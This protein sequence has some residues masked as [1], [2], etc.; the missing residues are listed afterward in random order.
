MA[1]TGSGT[2]TRVTIGQ[3]GIFYGWPQGVVTLSRYAAIIGYAEPA[4]WGVAHPDN[5]KYACREIWTKPQRDNVARYLVEAQADIEET[6]HYPLEPKWFEDTIPPVNNLASILA[7][8][9]RVIQMGRRAISTVQASAP[10]SHTQDPATIGP[11]L[12]TATDAD[13]IKVYYPGTDQEI[14]PVKVAISGGM[15]TIWIPRVRM[16]HP[17]KMDNPS[18]GLDYADLGNFLDAVDVYRV[19]NSPAITGELVWRK[20]TYNASTVENSS[21]VATIVDAKRGVIAVNPTAD[22]PYCAGRTY[23]TGITL[24]YQAGLLELPQIGEDAIMRLAHSKMPAEPCGC[25]GVRLVWK[26]DADIPQFMSRE[27][28]NCPYGMNTG[29]WIAYQFAASMTAWRMSSWGGG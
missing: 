7:P 6:I 26:R 2:G 1:S 9:N 14:E 20:D 17:D 28:L 4:F 8:Q 27:R 21:A 25:E 24:Y 18:T 22:P 13:E 19:Y 12:T 15:V 29:A 3:T 5:R 10:V 11:L 16:V 23:L